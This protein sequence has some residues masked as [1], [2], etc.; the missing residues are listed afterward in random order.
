MKCSQCKRN[1]PDHLLAPLHFNE[2]VIPNVCP[3][4]A[5]ELLNIRHGLECETL[6]GETAEA[7]RLEAIQYLEDHPNG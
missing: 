4:C 2:D 1:F 6:G 7:M 3:I 5:L